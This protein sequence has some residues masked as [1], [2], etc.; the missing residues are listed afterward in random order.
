ML[1][2]N[3]RIAIDT[4]FHSD[5]EEIWFD[6][7][8]TLWSHGTV[9]IIGK[10]APAGT[11]GAALITA[12]WWLNG[13]FILDEW[14]YCYTNCVHDLGSTDFIIIE[15]NIVLTL[16]LCIKNPSKGL[17]K[18]LILILDVTRL[19]KVI[20]TY[21]VGYHCQSPKL[22]WGMGVADKFDHLR[23]SAS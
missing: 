6:S 20:E 4:S 9:Y 1:V 14:N 2:F 3:A 11:S 17:E 10:Q 23:M 8:L 18:G 16:C 22:N 5:Q 15:L 21:R 12:W 13:I 19:M 7:L